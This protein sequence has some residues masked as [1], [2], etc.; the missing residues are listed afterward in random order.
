MNIGLPDFT[1]LRTLAVK[2]VEHVQGE[3]PSDQLTATAVALVA[4]AEAAH[5]DPFE[6]V[7]LALRVMNH[8][9]GPFTHQVQA[10]RDYAKQEIARL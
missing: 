10:I 4:M 6:V 3:R 5:L 1:A 9:E 8:A 7:A 2:Q